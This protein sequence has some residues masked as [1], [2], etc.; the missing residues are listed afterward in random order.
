M[1]S[2]YKSRF[3][4]ALL[5]LG[6]TGFFFIH[7]LKI[8]FDLST[9][10]IFIEGDPAYEFYQN[11]YLPE[12]SSLGVPGILAIE[13]KN[14]Q[15]PLSAIELAAKK[16]KA[17]PHV[18]Q[19]ISPSDQP[20]IMPSPQ[21]MK[22]SPAVIDGKLTNEARTYF[23]KH[24]L[25]QGVFLSKDQKSMALAFTLDLEYQ[26]QD[27][28]ELAVLS[29]EKDI[30]ALKKGLP[31]YNLY[32]ASP[33]FIQNQIVTLLKSDQINLIPYLAVFMVFLLLLMTKHPL[34]A[35]YPLLIVSLAI[36]CTM[37]FLSIIG[38]KINV[39]N[40]SI[41]ILILSI[42]IADSVHIYTRFIEESI[43]QRK[44]LKEG[45]KPNKA[46]IIT[47]TIKAMLLPCFLTTATTALGFFA[48]GAAGVEIIQQFGFD[49]AVGVIFCFTITFLLMPFLLSLHPIPKSHSASWLRWW[50]K[51]LSI[52]GM[53]QYS[54]GKS[55]H[56]AK[57]LSAVSAILMVFSIYASQGLKS[58][59]TW[60][61]ELP[62]D[63]PTMVSLS[64]V[65]NNFGGIMP[66]YIVFSGSKETLASYE[67][68]KVIDEIAKKLRA[69]DANLTVRS[70]IDAIDFILEQNPRPLELSA[71]DPDTFNELRAMTSNADAP[72]WS[73]DKNHLRLEGFLPNMTIN[74]AEE[75]RH[76]LLKIAAENP[77]AGVTITPTG[78][79]I[80]SSKAL[81]NITNDMKNSLA[82]ACL[83]ITIFIAIFFR[84]LRYALIAMLPNLVPIG[85]T[86]AL[87]SIFNLDV[88]LATVMIFSMALGLSIDTCIHLLCRVKE[89]I[90]K[91]PKGFQKL[92]LIRSIHRAFKGSGR[93]II[94][95]TAILLGGFSV[96]MFSRFLAMH[97][98]AII[99]TIV[100]LSALFADIILLPAFI[101]VTRRRNPEKEV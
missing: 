38:H 69:Y 58:N 22:V 49:T 85:L 14:G 92:S 94:Y 28:Q 48:S 45:E 65:E 66:F 77:I 26:N 1:P 27:K 16:L 57:L 37:G 56:Y 18:S 11:S 5:A 7:A 62:K 47:D 34:G 55:L 35:F 50:P 46:L 88:R 67:T 41:I 90:R 17:N 98:F 53:L 19:V 2:L 74:K 36:V 83:Y 8:E 80:I 99:S 10:T 82:L 71:I 30:D 25:Y 100:I 89:E 4:F 13:P 9:E 29:V 39:V 12:F 93:P 68:A 73:K 60:V 75:F 54:I 21:G 76:F 59:Q 70:P 61:G 84:S 15:D 20:I 51:K 40:N 6:L 64:F 52:D 24:P 31:D 63:D 86:I 91:M 72:F 32:V 33:P 97:D 44:L 101:W 3:I 96:L 23:S 79:S 43:R 81:H 95:T 42:G 78:S 87:M